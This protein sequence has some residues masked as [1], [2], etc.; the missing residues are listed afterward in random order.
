S[1]GNP[2]NYSWNVFFTPVFS[3]FTGVLMGTIETLY[4]SKLLIRKSF[5]RKLIYKV[6]IYL[7]LTIIFLVGIS[8]VAN[9]IE[10]Q[11]PLF[12]KQVITN[13]FA[14][15]SNQAFWSVVLFIGAIL[16]VAQ[17]YAEVS[18][19]IGRGALVNFFTGKYYKPVEEERIY[20]FL[21]MKSSTT[22][23]EKLGHVKYFEM[24]REYFA[25]LTEPIIEYLGEIYQYAG[26]EVIVSW[27]L[28]NG[29]AD[30]NCI[31]CFFSMKVVLEKQRSKYIEQFGMVPEFKAGLHLGKVTTGEI[32]IIKKEIIFTGDVLNTTARIQALCNQNKV[33]NILSDDLVKRLAPGEQFRVQP[34]GEHTLRGRDERIALYTIS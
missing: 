18:D 7:G 31:R 9:S 30:N 32:G 13:V 1:T 8:A 34:L 27:K 21:D 14:F 28:K 10:L 26:D 33:D 6:F 16:V 11:I 17:F 19:N 24:L 3:V 2:Y 25:D 5:S 20:M 12:N 15:V 29:L 4:F 23:A 22:I